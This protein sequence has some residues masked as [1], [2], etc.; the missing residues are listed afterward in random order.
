MKGHGTLDIVTAGFPYNDINVIVEVLAE[1]AA[2]QDIPCTGMSLNT[3]D[4]FG[5]R[6][7]SYHLRLGAGALGAYIPAG[8]GDILL[9]LEAG[10]AARAAAETMGAHGVAFV[11]TWQYHPPH[12]VPYPPVSELL[13]KLARLMAVV[14]PV[15]AIRLG[16]EAGDRRIAQGLVDMAMLGALCGSGLL[17]FTVADVARVIGSR[18]RTTEQQRVLK[19]FHLGVAEIASAAP[20]LPPPAAVAR[21]PRG[22][23]A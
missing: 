10:C 3:R 17:P 4:T 14:V 6:P 8:E 7:S 21:S 16:E 23:V 5:L 20:T 22:R 11:N 13:E 1:T 9:G 19:A 15:D 2:R 18:Y 12:L